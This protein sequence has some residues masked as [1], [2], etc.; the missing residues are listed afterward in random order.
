MFL[1]IKRKSC[2]S[3]NLALNFSKSNQC[4]FLVSRLKSENCFGGIFILHF[5]SREVEMQKKKKMTK[6]LKHQGIFVK[7]HSIKAQLL[8]SPERLEGKLFSNH[9]TL[10]SRYFTI[11]SACQIKPIIV[12]L[13]LNC[14]CQGRQ[15]SFVF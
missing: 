6:G 13:F 12:Y 9:E 1:Y 7:Q 14:S 10:S 3:S 11:C 5:L 2:F 8:L 15:Q 4:Q